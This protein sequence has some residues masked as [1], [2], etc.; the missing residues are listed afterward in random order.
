[1][2]FVVERR[3]TLG[4]VGPFDP[5]ETRGEAGQR[6]GRQW[7]RGP[8]EFGR[9]AVMRTRVTER[10]DNGRLLVAPGPR[11]DAGCRA[12]DRVAPVGAGDDPDVERVAFLAREGRRLR[13]DIDLRDSGRLMHRDP[14]VGSR[15]G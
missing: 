1:K 5:D 14:A 15:G 3:E 7:P 11:R 4:L 2:I 13:T 8:V 10:G 12:A 6:H 9:D